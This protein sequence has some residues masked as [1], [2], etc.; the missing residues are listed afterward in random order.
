MVKEAPSMDSIK[1]FWKEIW[2]EKKLVVCLQ[3]GW[4]IW[5]KEMGN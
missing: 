1:K 3:S 5:R 4:R 2:G